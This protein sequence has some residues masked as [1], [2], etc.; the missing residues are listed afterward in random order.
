MNVCYENKSVDPTKF[1]IQFETWSRSTDESYPLST[2]GDI[3]I[4]AKQTKTCETVRP[5]KDYVLT[6]FIFAYEASK[7]ITFI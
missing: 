1:T 3:D 2:I 5:E 7:G 4:A 6:E